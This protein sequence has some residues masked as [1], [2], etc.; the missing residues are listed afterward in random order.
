MAD[1]GQP[2]GY[3][4][5]SI[6]NPNG[7]DDAPIIIY[8]YTPTLALNVLAL[9]LYALL[10]LLHIY[11]LALTRR[12]KTTRAF[13]TL[14]LITAVF[15]IVGYVF[16]LRSS[17]PPV[18]NPYN[19]INFVVQ[20]FFIVVAPVF[21]SGGI[22]TVLTCLIAMVGEEYSPV[23]LGRKTIIGVFVASDVV[24]TIVQ[25]AGAALIGVAESDGKSPD[26]ANN[27]LLG[28]LA[29]QVFSFLLFLVLLGLFLG[30][31]RKVITSANVAETS[32]IFQQGK[33][34]GMKAFISAFVTASMLVYLRTI[35]RLA[36][37]CQGV[38]GYASSHEAFFGALEF[39]PVVLAVGILGVW[40]PG[41]FVERSI[42][43]AED[44]TRKRRFRLV[45][46]T[47]SILPKGAVDLS[48][49]TIPYRYEK[50]FILINLNMQTYLPTEPAALPLVAGLA[51]N[52][53]FLYGNLGAWTTGVIPYVLSQGSS[54]EVVK[55]SNWFIEKGK[56]TFFT[57]SVLSALLFTTSA[58]LA[59][60]HSKTR[61]LTLIAA[62]ASAL[63]LPYTGL[64]MLPTNNALAEIE[65]A[66]PSALE[67]NKE[68]K[69]RTRE[70]V[71]TWKRLHLGRIILGGVGW[72]AGVGGLVG[73]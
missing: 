58:I 19:V 1:E 23:G 64:L 49:P 42:D 9:I 71:G 63:V 54:F 72:A 73:L 30:K 6:P 8:G 43:E 35:F 39:A 5:P 13:S 69:K 28:G 37:T 24:A 51:T 47:S 17:P 61:N 26:T 2:D 7:P 41:L 59:P 55:G 53:Y 11:R 52:S 68:E 48:L 16:R 70:L 67:E 22:Y 40:H 60:P 15:E 18:G 32:P 33:L 65:A 25:I 4:D 57:S 21:I 3:V 62:L 34:G 44:R 36:E 46:I 29:F 12:N 31:A 27:I 20:Y 56:I 14:A 50:A 10:L 45:G 66:G 38:G